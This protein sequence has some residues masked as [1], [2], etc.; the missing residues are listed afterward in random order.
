MAIFRT[1]DRCGAPIPYTNQVPRRLCHRTTVKGSILFDSFDSHR[2][3]CNGEV[4]LCKECDNSFIDWFN[5][6]SGERKLKKLKD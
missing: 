1:C 4:D 5:A 6:G 2:F 3:E